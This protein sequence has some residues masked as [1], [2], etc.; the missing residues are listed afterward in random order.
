MLGYLH[1]FQPDS[2]LRPADANIVLLGIH[3][4]F[5]SEDK[6]ES[7]RDRD[8]IPDER[9]GCPD[10]PED[11]DQFEDYDGCPD[12]DNDKDGVADSVD[13]CVNVPEDRDGFE[14]EDGCPENDN[15]KD[16][17][18]DAKDKCPNDPEDKDGFLD[19]DGCPDKDND[20]DGIPD[21]DDI[22]PNEPETKNGYA[23]QDG[24]PDE[25]QVRVLGDKIL[26]DDRVHFQ[27]FSHEIGAVS[28]PLLTRLAK[29]IKEHPEYVHVDIGGHADERGGESL[30]LKL[31]QNRARAVLDFL[32]SRGVSASR[33]SSQGFGSSRP[34]V[35]KSSEHAWLMNRRVEFRVTRELKQTL[36][37]SKAPASAPPPPAIKPAPPAKDKK[38]GGA[39]KGGAEADPEPSGGG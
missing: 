25:E 7:D 5:G 36:R 30:N 31:S 15:D 1:V 29:L 24:C 8:G 21:L 20:Q 6:P 34:L 17:L 35:D 38:K 16:G 10:E 33:L 28:Y 12:I 19:E 23:D 37:S 11:I 26:L 32:V 4:F 27:E 18:V 39:D 13:R 14:D 22:C 9:D 3:A 2:E